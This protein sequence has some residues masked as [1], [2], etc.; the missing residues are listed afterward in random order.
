MELL[1]RMLLSSSIKQK[2]PKVTNN[3]LLTVLAL[4]ALP[5]KVFAAKETP[6]KVEIKGYLLDV[7]K[8][9][10]DAGIEVSDIDE[11]VVALSDP[12]LG[13][14]IYLG[15][16][17]YQIIAS[18]GVYKISLVIANADASQSSI[19][20]ISLDQVLP[21]DGGTID[22]SDFDISDFKYNLISTSSSTSNVDLVGMAVAGVTMIVA[23]ISKSSATSESLEGVI[24]EGL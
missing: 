17:I 1:S 7:A 12:S 18:S 15:N 22:Y 4:A 11:L 3:H 2:I 23:A 19:E 21:L 5:S 8:L 14:L 16:G 13:E 24:S 6:E 20:L 10:K 9:A